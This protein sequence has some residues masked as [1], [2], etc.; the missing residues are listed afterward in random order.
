MARKAHIW[1][2]ITFMPM[3]SGDVVNEMNLRKLQQVH[4]IRRSFMY[5]WGKII[6]YNAVKMRDVDECRI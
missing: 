3:S 2:E 1:T 5:T 4:I 6:T